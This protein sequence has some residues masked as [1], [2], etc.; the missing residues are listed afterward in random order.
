MFMQQEFY[1]ERRGH[2]GKKLHLLNIGKTL[3]KFIDIQ[4]SIAP[5]IVGINNRRFPPC[6]TG[7]Q[8]VDCIA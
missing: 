4:H 3:K 6:P 7:D 1:Y 5:D 8:T 2:N